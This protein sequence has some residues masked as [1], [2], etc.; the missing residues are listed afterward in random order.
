MQ[1]VFK[2]PNN[3][4]VAFSFVG[5]IVVSQLLVLNM[6]YRIPIYFLLILLLLCGIIFWS[7]ID[8]K[9]TINEDQLIS[10]VGPFVQKLNISELNKAIVVTRR[11]LGNRR[12]ITTVTL[13][14]ANDKKK[15]EFNPA[16]LEAFLRALQAQN[17]TLNIQR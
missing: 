11:R 16:D 6:G 1:Q 8:T 3:Y 10:K 2:Q 15:L 4:I 14:D 7:M 9:C 17:K 12:D 5:L 13:Y